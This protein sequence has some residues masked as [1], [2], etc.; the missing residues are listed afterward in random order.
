VRPGLRAPWTILRHWVGSLPVVQYN[1]R[2]RRSRA[3]SLAVSV[4]ES[5]EP[6][7]P[8]SRADPLASVSYFSPFSYHPVLGQLVARPPLPEEDEKNLPFR[9]SLY[10]VLYS[11]AGKS[12]VP[13]HGT[14]FGLS[15]VCQIN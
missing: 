7:C 3:G 2:Q 8:S 15:V 1:P 4:A 10:H 9:P 14:K 5:M 6:H 12:V 13:W 11:L